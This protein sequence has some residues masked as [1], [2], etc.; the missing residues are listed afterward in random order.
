M[1]AARKG[2]EAG[3]E[4][5]LIRPTPDVIVGKYCH[6]DFRDFEIYFRKLPVVRC[7]GIP[8]P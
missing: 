8:I 2:T 7:I 4:L 5:I 6:P 1:D 3:A